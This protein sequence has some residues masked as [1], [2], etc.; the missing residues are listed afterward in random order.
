M[1]LFL[2]KVLI[3]IVN[4][5][6]TGSASICCSCGLGGVFDLCLVLGWSR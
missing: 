4:I 2:L 5:E 6:F 1:G 3:F